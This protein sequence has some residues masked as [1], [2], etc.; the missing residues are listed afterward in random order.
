MILCKM[1]STVLG[2]DIA[3]F[4]FNGID[5]SFHGVHCLSHTLCKAIF[6]LNV[7][8]NTQI[9]VKDYLLS[10][11]CSVREVEN[12]KPRTAFAFP[13]ILCLLTSLASPMS[14]DLLLVIPHSIPQSSIF[15]SGKERFPCPYPSATNELSEA[16]FLE[17]IPGVTNILPY[18]SACLWA[19]LRE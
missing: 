16:K 4:V 7:K 3:L 6:S 14:Y 13:M 18:R 17:D 19:S 10:N 15:S 9:H 2:L 1:E 8:F 5:Q 12:N 11:W